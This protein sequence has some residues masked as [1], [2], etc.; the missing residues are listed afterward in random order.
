MGIPANR[1]KRSLLL[2]LKKG[3]A[4]DVF[5]RLVQWADV[6]NVNQV[7]RQL[8]EIGAS[9]R[10]IR[11]ANPTAILAHFDAYGG[12]NQGPRSQYIGYDDLLQASTGIMSRFGGSIN[13][14]EEHAHLGTIDVVSGVQGAAAVALALLHRE[15]TGCAEIA[16]TSLAAGGCALQT[17]FLYDYAGRTAFN[18]PSGRA[19][20]GENALYRW[21]RCSDGFV[22]VASRCNDDALHQFKQVP[23]LSEAFA[24]VDGHAAEDLLHS[25][26]FQED[27]DVC[28]RG[29]SQ[30]QALHQLTQAGIPATAQGFLNKLRETHIR[31]VTKVSLRPQAGVD[32][33]TMQW[34]RE[35]DH[36]VGHPVEMYSPC[37]VRPWNATVVVP[38]MQPQHGHQTREVLQELGLSRQRVD[39]LLRDKVAAV[40]WSDKYVPEGDPWAVQDQERFGALAPQAARAKL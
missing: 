25:F 37:S 1:G 5:R 27:M 20:K 38:C 7:S 10:M 23:M 26:R 39:E 36:P 3:D 34:T 2:D 8:T 35:E 19:A 12:P 4:K 40:S 21:Y 14:P 24:T 13:T 18:E 33:S 29:V 11:E 9:P 31:D 32:N 6:V 16:R 30:Q 22:F 17:P 28:F 15:R